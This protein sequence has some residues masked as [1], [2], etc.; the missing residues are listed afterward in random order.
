MKADIH[1]INRDSLK[2]FDKFVSYVFCEEVTL[3]TKS[4]PIFM[5]IHAETN[6][7]ERY[8]PRKDRVPTIIKLGADINAAF[9]YLFIMIS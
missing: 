3:N 2:C 9:V 6:S 4:I 7:G 1:V 5:S 8:K